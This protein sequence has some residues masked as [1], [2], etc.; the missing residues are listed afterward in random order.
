MFCEAARPF[1]LSFHPHIGGRMLLF[2]GPV[3]LAGCVACLSACQPQAPA[4]QSAAAVEA[5]RTADVAWE[6]AF[7]A[8]DTTAAVAAVEPSGSVLPPNAPIATG[9]A[10]IRALFTGYYALPGMTLHWQPVSIEAARSGELAYSRGTYELSFT[11][12]KG[13]PMT[14]HGKY[15]TIW[16]KQADG[17]WKVVVD[18]FNSDSP[19]PG[20]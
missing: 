7:S 12:P 18:I 4:D 8:R 13:K 3:F 19:V 9:P 16:R 15:A 17:S 20:M 1:A 5:V 2:R 14:D 6:K 11:D 10:A